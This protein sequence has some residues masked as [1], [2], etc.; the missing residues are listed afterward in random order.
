MSTNAPITL[1]R[2]NDETVRLAIKDGDS[3]HPLNEFAVIEFVVKRS[4]NDSDQNATVLSSARN[5]IV[6]DD[7]RN[8]LAHVN[9]PGSVISEA[10][11]AWYRV[12]LIS[13]DGSRNT[14]AM[15]NLTV[16]AV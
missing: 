15:G 8:G 10:K 1:M 6:V 13:P 4:Q 5:E 2:G 14:V 11:R 9:V 12:D 16:Q 3:P 7:H